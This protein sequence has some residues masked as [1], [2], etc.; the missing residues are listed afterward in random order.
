MQTILRKETNHPQNIRHK[1]RPN[2]TNPEP[3][4][5]NDSGFAL[6]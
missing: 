2:A 6:S 3:F 5:M 4:I 1:S